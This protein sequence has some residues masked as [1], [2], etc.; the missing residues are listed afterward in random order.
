[1]SDEPQVRPKRRPRYRGRNPRRF[2][3]KYK[4]H[5][6]IRYADAV[7]HIVASGKTPAGSHRPILVSEILSVLTPRP[8]DVAVDATLGFG[9]HATHLL[10][11]ILPGGRLLGL[12]V[13][14]IELPKTEERLRQ[15][16]FN[17]DVL[18]VMRTNFAG[19]PQALAASGLE[20]ADVILADLGLS[21]MQIDN[22]AR[23][24]TFKWDGPFDLRLNPQRGQPASVFVSRLAVDE[25][26]GILRDYSDEP[27]APAIAASLCEAAAQ[28]KLSTTLQAA[29]AIR[30]VLDL[31]SNARRGHDFDATIRRVF[32]AVRI[33][34]NDEFGALEMFLR[35]LPACL[36]AGG[37]VAILT[38][39]SGE[40]RR[41]KQALQLG[42]RTGE[43]ST[44]A[45]EVIR[46]SSEE[47]RSNP[48]ASSAKLRWA[49]RSP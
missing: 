41:V 36:K 16:G 11:A 32:Q 23:G 27:Q 9:G 8:G 17:A 30:R 43:Y 7:A 33:A 40:D 18:T 45:D 20:S 19:L 37:R 12:D 21:S 29:D 6:P 28:E 34:V 3:E 31:E 42:R 14:P 15:A 2:E 10:E 46:P 24:F 48:R 38:F 25:L 44:I 13:D 26:A 1:M 39:H 49:I 22:P 4:E 47:T 35:N 5:D